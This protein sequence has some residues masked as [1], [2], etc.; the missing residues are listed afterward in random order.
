MATG[1][2]DWRD[3][4][5]YPTVGSNFYSPISY[6]E[7]ATPIDIQEEVANEAN[8]LAYQRA[9]EAS[10]LNQDIGQLSLASALMKVAFP[11]ERIPDYGQS[12]SGMRDS[13]LTAGGSISEQAKEFGN[14][15]VVAWMKKNGIPRTKDQLEKFMDATNANHNQLDN[16]NKMY[17][18]FKWGDMAKI[19]LRNADGSTEIYHRFKG[20]PGYRLLLSQP[21][22]FDSGEDLRAVAAFEKGQKAVAKTTR[23][24]VLA[25]ELA[26]VTTQEAYDKITAQAEPGII[27]EAI[28]IAQGM[29]PQLE[30]RFVYTFDHFI[31]TEDGRLVR[32][33]PGSSEWTTLSEDVTYINQSQDKE[34][35]ALWKER[36]EKTTVAQRND[37]ILQAVKFS[38][39]SS[40]ERGGQL[41]PT[42]SLARRLAEVFTEAGIPFDPSNL[43]TEIDAFYDKEYHQKQASAIH[44][45][46][47]TKYLA[48][49]AEA[50]TLSAS[51]FMKWIAKNK[52][53]AATSEALT[54]QLEKNYPGTPYKGAN[55]L[56]NRNGNY[57]RINTVAGA[58]AAQKGGYTY[59]D[60][61]KVPYANLLQDFNLGAINH[62]A[63]TFV[64]TGWKKTGGE[65]TGE[66]PG[67]ENVRETRYTDKGARI[68]YTRYRTEIAPTFK[69]ID[70]VY[71]TTARV[72]EL[73][74]QA[75]GTGDGFAIKSIEK[76]LD[77]TGV[78]RA[79]DVEFLLQMGGYK[80]KF[81]QLW[82]KLV[83]REQDLDEALSPQ[84]R[85][86]LARAL[87][88]VYRRDVEKYV[89]R[90]EFAK[91]DFEQIADHGGGEGKPILVME[92][93]SLDWNLVASP[94]RW[95][96]AVGTFDTK[97]DKYGIIHDLGY[98][99]EVKS[100]G[101]TKKK[102]DGSK[103]RKI[104][105][106]WKVKKSK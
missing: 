105:D 45:E 55:V 43:K 77:P 6:L 11:N 92:G 53:G 59:A 31:S 23:T 100:L 41:E 64:A 14:D 71:A 25:E 26:G 69:D 1:I 86:A 84:F 29:N 98:D 91:A 103:G 78:V 81:L 46:K 88:V 80:E 83:T 97:G 44:F 76:I 30:K 74:N 4:R 54:K 50:N 21:N 67:R 32:A 95:N 19:Y 75:G 58:I 101:K 2:F 73:L 24:E 62:D 65:D 18:L 5:K 22:T 10:S 39:A 72:L 47:G 93:R 40:A 57:K 104:V 51:G 38:I 102:T 28:K 42:D 68:F 3:Q 27:L 60:F 7:E 94:R 15:R 89:G 106:D 79:S 8:R 48:D 35:Y 12:L 96:D 37:I 99:L 66:A 33:K 52:V 49:Q 20:S 13:A 87:L 85:A 61:N 9:K 82:N 16:I 90:L 36:S 56:Y 63:E 34:A 17:N 70:T